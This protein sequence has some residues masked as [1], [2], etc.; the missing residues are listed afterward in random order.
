MTFYETLEIDSDAT[1]ETIKKQYRKL[2][3]DHHP[4]RP[5]GNAAKFKDINEAYETLSDPA[6]KKEYDFFLNHANNPEAALFEMLFKGGGADM[7]M[8]PPM[9]F[10][11][12]Q[13]K[14]PPLIVHLSLTLDQVYTG[15]TVP[16]EISRSVVENR[17][18][19]VEKETCYVDIPPGID[20]NEMILL[21]QK[22]NVGPDYE[23][24]DVK[25]VVL[26]ENKTKLV[27]QGLDLVYTQTLTLKEALCG[28]SFD[29][30]FLQGKQLKITNQAGNIVS[31]S[32]KKTIPG[33]GMKRDKKEGSLIIAFSIEFPSSLSEE[34]METL[35][36]TL[37]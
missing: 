30:M 10:H 15:C 21:E 19:R 20:N 8:Q 16:V 9:F 6:K 4:D 26:V 35:K 12:V 25:I 22:G 18:K 32:L 24:G 7:F 31:P 14:P 33:M 13:L 3:L 17:K 23:V 11:P 28:F 27:R 2:S 5:S 34:Q 37:P 29:L 36:S 1:A